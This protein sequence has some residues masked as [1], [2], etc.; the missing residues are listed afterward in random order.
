LAEYKL[1]L[2]PEKYEF[3]QKRIEYLKLVISENKVE[4]N[5]VK[6]SSVC[7]WPVPKS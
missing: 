5:P 6:I 7:E 2:Y 1:F 4:M 3:E